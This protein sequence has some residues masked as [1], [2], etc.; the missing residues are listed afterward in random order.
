MSR[1]PARLLGAAMIA[2]TLLGAGDPARAVCTP[3]SLSRHEAIE[4]LRLIP[5]AVI[6]RRSGAT[7]SAFPWRAGL[8]A[9]FWSFML[10][11]SPPTHTFLD[12]GIMGYFSVNRR[13]ARV[14]DLNLEVVHGIELDRYR[15]RIVRTHCLHG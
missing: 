2:T 6:A 11:G 1:D 10:M 15:R 12:N 4:T 3:R 14:I 13:T 9:D 8:G 7:V 5:R